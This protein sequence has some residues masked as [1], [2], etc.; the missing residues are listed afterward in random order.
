M[1]Q[2]IT[3][4]HQKGGVGKST[5]SFN[6]AHVFKNGLK[7]G[8]CDTDLQGSLSNLQL[9][10]DGIEILP[11]PNEISTLK[12]FDHEI[13]IIDTPPYLSNKLSDLF[14]I[15][16]F[17]LIP[18]KAGFL[19]YM[20]IKSTIVLLKESMQKSPTVKAGIVFNMIKQQATIKAEVEKLLEDSAIDIMQTFITD[21]VS[22]T[23]SVIT[24]G[25]L[26]ST[27]E[28]AKKEII[29]LADEILNRIGI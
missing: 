26:K 6:L 9:E 25:I 28:K 29:S 7:V 22:Y 18:T 5:L 12:L 17:I 15:S 21:R 10:V 13:I 2:I 24:G 14:A 20:A 3:I 27:D 8:L 16:N 1:P 11:I 4:A 23:R 19:D